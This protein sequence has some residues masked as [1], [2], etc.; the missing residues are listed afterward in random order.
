VSTVDEFD[1]GWDTR[2]TLVEGRWVE[3]TPRRPENEP[4]VRREASLMPWLAP[5]LPLPVATPWIVSEHPLT[6]RHALIMGGP[7]PGT[8]ARHGQLVGEFLS[9][10]H[11]VDADE[12][13]RHGAPDAEE[14]FGAAQAIRDRMATHVLPML[15]EHVR[16]VGYG[17]L[18]RMATAPP[19]PRLVHGDLG[20]AHIR[21]VGEDVGGVID[22]GDCCVGDPALDLSWTLYGSARP[23][24]ES[25]ASA[26]RPT[27]EQ[28]ERARDWHVVGPWHEVLYGLDTRQ[29]GFVESGLSGVVL[30]LERFAD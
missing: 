9:V 1:D 10:L 23:F 17:L 8:S 29:H 16:S 22:W 28:V 5:M 12:A 13:V 3:R 25:L 24:A 19:E 27:E 14:S 6:V 15:P 2:A 30:R 11:R 18:E 20:P 7:C 4:Q 21:V 26:Y